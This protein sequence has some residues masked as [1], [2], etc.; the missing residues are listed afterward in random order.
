VKISS[1]GHC[2]AVSF[3][4]TGSKRS[5][6]PQIAKKI[7]LECGS[8]KDDGL[9]QKQLLSPIN[10]Q[11]QVANGSPSNSVNSYRCL[12][13]LRICGG[14]S[15]IREHIKM[16]HGQT[17][18]TLI[19]T[20]E[21]PSL[22]KRILKLA[23]KV[24][25]VSRRRTRGESKFYDPSSQLDSVDETLPRLVVKIQG[26]VVTACSVLSPRRPQ[27]TDSTEKNPFSCEFCSQKFVTHDDY[28]LHVV[29]HKGAAIRSCN[30]C[31]KTFLH[32]EFFEQHM[33][34]SHNVSV[35]LSSG[36]HKS[37]AKRK[38]R[39]K[40]LSKFKSKILESTAATI[41]SPTSPLR[42]DVTDTQISL[43]TDVPELMDDSK[44]KDNIEP[45]ENHHLVCSSPANGLLSEIYRNIL[46]LND[47]ANQFVDDPSESYLNICDSTTQSTDLVVGLP[48]QQLAIYIPPQDVVQKSTIPYSVAADPISPPLPGERNTISPYFIVPSMEWFCPDVSKG[49]VKGTTKDGNLVENSFR[50]LEMLS[51]I[52]TLEP[53]VISPGENNSADKTPNGAEFTPLAVIRSGP[54]NEHMLKENFNTTQNGFS[55]KLDSVIRI[56]GRERQFYSVTTENEN[57]Q[58]VFDVKSDAKDWSRR[59]CPNCCVNYENQ[60]ALEDHI[61]KVHDP[62]NVSI[63]AVWD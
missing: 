23:K 36:K 53:H 63:A 18:Q 15:V 57:S 10:N 54:E 6:G 35:K 9:N 16:S 30:Q 17:L 14:E 20:D 24:S 46:P 33:T 3:T 27:L 52:A 21:D 12:M 34:E 50:N 39:L 58:K 43:S 32:S 37:R 25:S 22:G 48:D 55:E 62:K 42:C 5:S 45:L 19:R 56:A 38:V 8:I 2:S 44:E 40:A 28:L 4:C 13:C 47:V 31:G 61:A 49:R 59:Q 60:L 1:R 29:H 11:N 51:L 26:Q 41:S 7:V